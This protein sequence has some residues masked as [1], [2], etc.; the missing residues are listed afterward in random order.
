MAVTEEEVKKSRRDAFRERLSSRYPDLQMDDE[1]AFYG[2]IDDDYS[3]YERQIED[4][5]GREK[6]LADMFMA[7][8]KSAVF[9]TEW[10][11]TGDPYGSLVRMFGPDFNDFIQ[12]PANADKIAEANKEFAERIADEDR[13]EEEYKKNIEQSLADIQKY[14]EENGLTDEQ[15]GDAMNTLQEISM[16]MIV[17]K[18]PVDVLKMI[19]NAKNYDKAV[20][21]AGMEGEVRGRN[22][23]IR[24]QLRKR[25]SSDGVPS[26]SGKNTAGVKPERRS[27]GALDRMADNGSIWDK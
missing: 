18:I 11:K 8:P 4:Y 6:E 5:R 16:N 17:G 1:E 9:L 25:N 26:M 23:K 24:E 10:R 2:R 14:Q 3:D 22:A 15:V 21:T 19:F 27:N 13:L 12:D 20:E 7:N